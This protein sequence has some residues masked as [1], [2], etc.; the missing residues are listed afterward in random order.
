MAKLNYFII[1]IQSQDF[2]QALIILSILLA[3]GLYNFVQSYE[4]H[5]L[6]EVYQNNV[7]FYMQ[8]FR[9]FGSKFLSH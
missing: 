6:L 4:L 8:H 7:T 2:L 3:D 1:Y 5:Q 9:F